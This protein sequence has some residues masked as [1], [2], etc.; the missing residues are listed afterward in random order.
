MFEL[1][2]RGLLDADS[3]GGGTPTEPVVQDP[4]APTE[5]ATEPD[6]VVAEPVAP[7]QEPLDGKLTDEKGV[8]LARFQKV[9]AKLADSMKEVERLKME[10]LVYKG[11]D[12]RTQP[13]PALAAKPGPVEPDIIRQARD[14]PRW[15]PFMD[16]IDELIG[17]KLDPV[18]KEFGEFRDTYGRTQA[19]TAQ[20][21]AE[22]S[23]DAGLASQEE[24]VHTEV[25]AM[26][27]RIPVEMQK[28]VKMMAQN[29]AED[30][31]IQKYKGRLVDLMTGKAIPGMSDLVIEDYKATYKALY[32][33]EVERGKQFV[34]DMA[35]GRQKKI[36]AAEVAQPAIP[37]APGGVVNPDADY[38]KQLWQEKKISEDDYVH[39]R[40][41]DHLKKKK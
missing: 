35:A 33:K 23:W 5:P 30:I 9:N 29:Q 2:T 15:K 16:G 27:E 8:P 36:D 3:G 39:G 37:G 6:G 1:W 12:Q 11:R 19:A 26:D 20:Q 24:I 34:L 32:I 31:V 40:I 17:Q 41:P 22:A 14:D 38:L 13:T 28:A 18:S 25:G 10:N 21:Q 4:I 7:G